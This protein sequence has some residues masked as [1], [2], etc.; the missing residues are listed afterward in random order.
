M[1]K[2]N[3]KINKKNHNYSLLIGSNLLNI[4]PRK[5]KAISPKGKNVAVVFD[6]KIPNSLKVKTLKTLNKYKKIKA[7]FRYGVGYEKQ[8]FKLG[9]YNIKFIIKK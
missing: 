7:I 3:I 9:E 4:L 1:K 2:I 5:L 6:K 8:K